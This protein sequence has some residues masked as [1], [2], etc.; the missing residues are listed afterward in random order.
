MDGAVNTD[1]ISPGSAI[2]LPAP[3]DYIDKHKAMKAGTHV[4]PQTEVSHISRA[5]M[6]SRLARESRGASG[7]AKCGD[8]T[9]PFVE[10]EGIVKADSIQ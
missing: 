7:K 6:L 9:E 10:W 5:V 1:G 3:Y 4:D 8:E 2:R